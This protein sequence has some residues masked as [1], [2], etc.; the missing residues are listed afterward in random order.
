VPGSHFRFEEDQVHRPLRWIRTGLRAV[1]L[2]LAG[3]ALALVLVTHLAP[4]LGYRLVIIRGSSMTPAI[5]LGALAFDQAAGPLDIAPGSVV[6]LTLP[7]GTVVTHRIV[8]V[9]AVNGHV[10]IATKG[11]ANAGDD[12]TMQ[13]A[14]AVYGVVRFTVPL[15][16]FLLA[17]LDLPSGIVTVLSMLGSILAAIWLLDDLLEAPASEAVPP[18][19]AA[20]GHRATA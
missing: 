20:Q 13:P 3:T 15:A 9:V 1:W 2:V 18:Q 14:A 16:G 17:F 4:Q 19:A 6:T 8:R 11:D 10:Q 7:S 12:P 5:P